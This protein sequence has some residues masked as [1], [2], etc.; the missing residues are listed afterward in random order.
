MEIPMDGNNIKKCFPWKYL[1]MALNFQKIFHGIP[2]SSIGGIQAYM[3][4]IFL[5]QFLQFGTK[6]QW[7]HLWMT[8][9]TKIK[10]HGNTYG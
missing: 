4:N 2:V 3:D 8:V 5:K 10:I 6:N 9:S 7:K 1:W